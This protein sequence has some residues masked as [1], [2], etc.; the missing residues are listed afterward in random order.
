M[1]Y[2]VGLRLGG[3]LRCERIGARN[4]VGLVA[5]GRT[6]SRTANGGLFAAKSLAGDMVV[7]PSNLTDWRW[8]ICDWRL[9]LR[10]RR[11]LLVQARELGVF[12]LPELIDPLLK[13]QF[14]GVVLVVIFAEKL[15]W[16]FDLLEAHYD[17][18]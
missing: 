1:R 15:R 12:S 10:G 14:V 11:E 3:V 2:G 16:N 13:G 9:A 18:L 5:A 4:W 17:S 8:Y 7:A 6:P